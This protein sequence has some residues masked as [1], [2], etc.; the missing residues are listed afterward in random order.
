VNPT[1]T[2]EID[3]CVSGSGGREEGCG[4]RVEHNID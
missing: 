3:A 2:N 1:L 4:R